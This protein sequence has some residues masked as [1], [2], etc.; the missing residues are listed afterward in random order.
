MGWFIPMGHYGLGLIR[1]LWI[2]LWFAASSLVYAQT[3]PQFHQ[4]SKLHLPVVIS[5]GGQPWSHIVWLHPH[6]N[7]TTSADLAIQFLRQQQRGCLYRFSQS[8]SRYV[9]FL[10]QGKSYRFDPNRIFTPKGRAQTLNCGGRGCKEAQQQL[11]QAVN[12]FIQQYLTQTR[13]MVALHNNRVGGLSVKHYAAGGDLATNVARLSLSD[14]ANR[15]DFFY[16]T[17]DRAFD[18]FARRHFNVVLQHNRQVRDD[19]SLSVWAADQQI[20]YINVEAGIHHAMAQQA[21][22][23]AVWTYM[24]YY[25][26][27]SVA[28]H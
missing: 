8:H 11:S 17:T 22:L 18:F 23:E 4:T 12:E 6:A 26:P 20:E 2:L 19:G 21:M 3:A 25:Y 7:E 5:C 28:A 14:Q 1:R 24:Q 9:T 27:E 10:V 15:D 13:L 16:V